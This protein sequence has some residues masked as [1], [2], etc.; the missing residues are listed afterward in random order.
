MG[1]IE[2]KVKI[3][4]ATMQGVDPMYTEPIVVVPSTSQGVVQ[5]KSENTY[6]EIWKAEGDYDDRSTGEKPYGC[7]GNII[8]E[9]ALDSTER[10]THMPS[11]V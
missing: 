6:R 8:R 1:K 4:D 3:E 7:T 2:T 10:N 5:T 9:E 11:P